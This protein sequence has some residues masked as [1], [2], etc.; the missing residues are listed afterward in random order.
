MR[1]FLLVDIGDMV[2]LT[3]TLSGASGNYYIQAIE[4]ETFK[5]GIIHVTYTLLE[6]ASLDVSYWLLETAVGVN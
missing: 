1:M 3:E 4:Y 5:G 6:A 2:R